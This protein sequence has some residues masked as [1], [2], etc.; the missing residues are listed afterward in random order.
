MYKYVSDVRWWVQMRQ[1]LN[2][3]DS[4]AD[5]RLYV[6]ST[7]ENYRICIFFGDCRSQ[8]VN[9]LMVEL[10]QNFQIIL[11]ASVW[12]CDFIDMFKIA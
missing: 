11:V 1:R 10:K 3:F 12:L 9:D 8:N 5:L 4:S 7:N 2:I 6:F